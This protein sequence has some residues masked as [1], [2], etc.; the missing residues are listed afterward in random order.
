MPPVMGAAAFIMAEL[1]QTSYGAVVIAALIPSFLYYA[2]LFACVDLEAAKGGIGAA[3]EENAP[4]FL[5]VLREGWHFLLPIAFLVVGLLFLEM[6]AERAAIY[7][8]L[9]LLAFNF[10]FSYRG[11]RCSVRELAR[12][13][14]DTGRASLDI[15]LIARG[16]GPRRGR[17][18]HHGA[19]LRADAATGDAERRQRVRAAAAPRRSEASSWAWACRRWASTCSPRR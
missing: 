4:K 11:K 6:Q 18:Q 8:A 5:E 17:A 10:I 2:T 19:R 14:L 1:L 9:M 16:C 7:S 13:L 3:R 15:I 12:A